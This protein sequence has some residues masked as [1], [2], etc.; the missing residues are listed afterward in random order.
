MK[1]TSAS[2]WARLV[3]TVAMALS[4]TAAI[5]AP[6]AAEDEPDDRSA[7]EEVRE[8]VLK[9]RE[10]VLAQIAAIMAG[11][12]D[13]E[14]PK[15]REIEEFEGE[16]EAEDGEA[17]DGEPEDGEPEDGEAEDGEPEDGEPEDGEGVGG[18]GEDGEEDGEGEDEEVNEVPGTGV[19]HL[20]GAGG[21]LPALIAAAGAFAAAGLSLRRR[22]G[23]DPART[24]R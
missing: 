19:G 15:L 3:A 4:L 6:V 8:L 24:A 22:F 5:S 18:E 23:E 12:D 9:Q 7:A 17:E 16:A 14:E 11:E 21:A 1:R 2:A 10:K 13:D 20:A